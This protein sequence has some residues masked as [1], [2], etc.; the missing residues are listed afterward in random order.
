M[1]QHICHVVKA[2]YSPGHSGSLWIFLNANDPVCQ[3]G[4]IILQHL[5][6]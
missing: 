4:A 1:A 5:D 6:A 3:C 2:I